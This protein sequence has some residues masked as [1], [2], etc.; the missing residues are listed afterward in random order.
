M[1]VGCMLSL[2]YCVEGHN[3]SDL[4]YVHESRTSIIWT[5]TRENLSS[6]FPSKRVSNQF[7]QLQSVISPVAS[8][9][10]ILSK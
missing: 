5:S 9:H 4:K 1:V 6:G 3:S 8:L 2:M 7:P 10:M